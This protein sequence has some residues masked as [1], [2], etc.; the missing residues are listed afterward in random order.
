MEIQYS[1]PLCSHQADSFFE[2]YFHCPNCDLRFLHPKRRLTAQAEKGRYDLHNN[3]FEDRAYRN[4]LLPLAE[5]VRSKIAP[6]AK[7]LDFGCGPAPVL[8]HILDEMGFE[9]KIYDPFFHP[10]KEALADVYDFICVSEV[11]EH[12][13]DPRKELKNLHALLQPGGLLAVMTAIYS[14]KIDF[15]SWYYRKDPTHVVFYSQATFSWIAQHLNFST[16]TFCGDRIAL[17]LKGR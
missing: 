7:G 13:Y 3:N 8:A 2:D 6:G 11:V 14:S 9:T 12:F 17:L 5:A 4:F 10:A 1:C 16:P 15:S